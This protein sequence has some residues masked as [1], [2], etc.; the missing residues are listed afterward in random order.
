MR[1]VT[2]QEKAKMIE[3]GQKLIRMRGEIID[4]NTEIENILDGVIVYN[5]IKQ[6]HH[7]LFS[8]M[9]LWENFTFSTKVKM[10]GKLKLPDE[11]ISTQ[12]NLVKRLNK[13]LEARNNFAHRLSLIHLNEVYLIGKDTKPFK[14]DDKKFKELL[15][16]AISIRESLE[17]LYFYQKGITPEMLE[18]AKTMWVDIK[19]IISPVD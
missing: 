9:L 19:D 1:E 17:A 4:A 16:E 14:I 18:N 2:P 8:D 15:E 5:L 11:L 13:M 7:D 6:E 10:F 12:E 3:L